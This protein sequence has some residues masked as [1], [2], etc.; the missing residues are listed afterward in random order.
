MNDIGT[1]IWKEMKDSVLQGGWS[2][3]IRPLL[4]LGI[5]G[6]VMPWRLGPQW[7]ALSPLVVGIDLY[8]PFIVILSFVGDA[9]AGERERHTLETLLASRIGDHAILLGKIIVTTGY[10]WGTALLGLL[11]GLIVANLSKGQGSW[12]FYTHGDV[13]LETLA[14]SLLANLLGVSGGVL[15]SLR[16]ATVRQAQQILIVAT[17]VLVTGGVLALKAVP[18]QDIASLSPSQFWLIAMAVLA[19]L[20]V[21]LLGIS[22]MS[23]R[24]SR[25]ILT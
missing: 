25:L 21:I 22:L 1:M 23:F 11:L 16:S 2:A 13:L 14:L 20:D 9:I 17:M 24:R 7:L 15:I 6:I 8:I 4:L 12:A 5:L 10:A 3:S 18:A 19:V